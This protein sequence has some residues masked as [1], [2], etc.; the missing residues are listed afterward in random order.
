M[1]WFSAGCSNASNIPYH[2]VNKEH[3]LPSYHCQAVEMLS[4]LLY[5]FLLAHVVVPAESWSCIEVKEKVLREGVLWR[6]QNCTKDIDVAPPL[7]TINSIHV[8]LNRD[9]IRVVPAIADPSK[10]VQ[11]LPDIGAQNPK[12]M[13]GIN[14]GKESKQCSRPPQ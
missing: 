13:A 8:D 4:N 14:G 1:I 5:L 6:V 2:F 12:L 11:S 7:L 9:D 3:L 10:G